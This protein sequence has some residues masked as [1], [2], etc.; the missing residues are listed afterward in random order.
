MNKIAKL[1]F[2]HNINQIFAKIGGEE[3]ADYPPEMREGGM[4]PGLAFAQAF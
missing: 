1:N 2:V 4:G 3:K